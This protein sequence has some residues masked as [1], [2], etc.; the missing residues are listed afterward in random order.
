MMNKSIETQQIGQPKSKSIFKIGHVTLNGEKRTII[1]AAV[2]E[3]TKALDTI[4]TLK[5]EQ[6]KDGETQT[7]T[8]KREEYSLTRVGFGL[9]VQNPEDTYN[10]VLGV[11]IASGRAFAPK[12]SLG[13]VA[14]RDG[15]LSL[16]VVELLLAEKLKHIHA[17]PEKYI[18]LVSK[19]EKALKLSKLAETKPG[20]LTAVR[21][22]E[23]PVV[24]PTAQ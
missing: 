4:T 17:N 9:S 3:R 10:E 12:A 19:E 5:S 22:V 21:T 11:S 20:K 16:T 24:K 14:S 1:L 2:Q 15:L 13:V 18:K 6:F 8:T 23:K 7:V